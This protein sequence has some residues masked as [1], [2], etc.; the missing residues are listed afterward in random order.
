MNR[1]NPA[2]GRTLV[3]A[4]E[5]SSKRVGVFCEEHG[6]S[7]AVLKYWRGRIAELDACTNSGTFVQVAAL[8]KAVGEASESNAAVVA[9]LPNNVRIAFRHGSDVNT[10]VIEALAQC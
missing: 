3:A 9:I 7:Y 10:S 8:P 6:V 1:M 5:R 4:F 2:A